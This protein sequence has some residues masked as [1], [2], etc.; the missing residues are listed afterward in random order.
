[1]QSC[2]VG[3]E[4]LPHSSTGSWS[5]PWHVSLCFQ[6]RGRLNSRENLHC[7]CKLYHFFF[8]HIVSKEVISSI[9]TRHPTPLFSSLPFHVQDVCLLFLPHH[10][11]LFVFTPMQDINYSSHEY[12]FRK[13][14]LPGLPSRSSKA[15]S[16]FWH[17][18]VDLFHSLFPWQLSLRDHRGFSRRQSAAVESLF[19]AGLKLWYSLASF[20]TSPPFPPCLFSPFTSGRT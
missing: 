2:Q 4:L 18:T 3:V 5:H 20:T 16:T 1:M 15:P 12:F 11:C 6:G 17:E 10:C 7:I 9:T 14:V 13:L 19:T 8:P